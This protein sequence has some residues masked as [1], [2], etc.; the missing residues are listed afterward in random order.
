MAKSPQLVL[1]VISA[2]Y[3]GFFLTESSAQRQICSYY[4]MNHLFI[5]LLFL[6]RPSVCILTKENV[7]A[8]VFMEIQQ[9]Y[10][11][12]FGV[13]EK[14]T[15]LHKIITVVIYSNSNDLIV[16]NI[17]RVLELLHEIHSIQFHTGHESLFEELPSL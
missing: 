3:A 5:L 11:T 7:L 15:Y 8:F 2:L 17:H 9:F 10:S 1:L 13:E 14:F 12:L 4:G 6:S 16:F